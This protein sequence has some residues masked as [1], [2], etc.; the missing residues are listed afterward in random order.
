MMS[1]DCLVVPAPEVRSVSFLLVPEWSDPS[2]WRALLV[3]F[4]RTF[5][6]AEGV[7]I[8][9]PYDPER[10]DVSG[11]EEFLGEVAAQAGQTLEAIADTV[12]LPVKKEPANWRELAGYLSAVL[13]PDAPLAHWQRELEVP[14]LLGSSQGALRAFAQRGSY[15][16]SRLNAQIQALSPRRR[17]IFESFLTLLSLEDLVAKSA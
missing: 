10:D 5:S 7:S 17:E 1:S 4:Y 14:V 16:L 12:L 15:E 13:V 2:P 8:V 3:E 9:L 6:S 11:I